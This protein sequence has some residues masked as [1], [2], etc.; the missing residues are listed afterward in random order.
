MSVNLLENK[1]TE[2]L[3]S[4]SEKKDINGVFRERKGVKEGTWQDVRP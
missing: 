4:L 3:K 1:R 2:M